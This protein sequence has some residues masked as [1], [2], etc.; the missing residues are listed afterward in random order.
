MG[1]KSLE[2]VT[3]PNVFFRALTKEEGMTACLERHTDEL[4]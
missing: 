1:G 4:E 3:A 2:Q